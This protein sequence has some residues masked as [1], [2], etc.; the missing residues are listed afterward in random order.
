MWTGT[1]RVLRDLGLKS[2]LLP[3]GAIDC[4]L[5]PRLLRDLQ[6]ASDSLV[7]ANHLHLLYLVTPYDLVDQARPN[8]MLYLDEVMF[9]M[10]EIDSCVVYFLKKIRL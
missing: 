1:Q 6:E 2:S 4:D 10:R 5:G 8:W 9:C 7:V 3:A